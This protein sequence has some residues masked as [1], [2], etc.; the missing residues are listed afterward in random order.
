MKRLCAALFLVSLAHAQDVPDLTTRPDLWPREVAL[1]APVEIPLVV[2]GKNV[3]T[4]TLP[5]G[6]SLPLTEVNGA[7]VH[8]TF[9][10]LPLIAP[11]K[12]TDLLVRVQRT[13]KQREA[14]RAS[15]PV[16]SPT[17]APAPAVP[18]PVPAA[19][20]GDLI[21]KEL[22]GSLVSLKNGNIAKFDDA[23]LGKVKYYAFY[24]SASWCPPCRKF[25]P[26]L[27]EFYNR[28]KPQHPEFELVLVDRDR[29]EADANKYMQSH[30]M[31]WP[32]VKFSEAKNKSKITGYM[33]P[34]IPCLVFV[35]GDGKVLSDSYVNGKYVG[36]GKVL[37][38]IEAKLGKQ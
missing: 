7:N 16:P 30:S 35:D 6:T 10:G 32:A 15:V 34:G 27:V 37:Q 36:P 24:Y 23:G 18:A 29:S 17:P 4:A 3:G 11:S 28:F 12:D 20:A 22:T 38:D 2:N 31:P 19:V 14:F 26:S 21:A 13:L 33:G 25:T 8:L 5:V 1:T 9:N